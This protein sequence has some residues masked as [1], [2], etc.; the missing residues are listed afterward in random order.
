MIRLLT[1]LLTPS[2]FALR[3]FPATVRAEI[4]TAVAGSEQRHRGEICVVI[5]GPLPFSLLWRDVPPRQRALD[6]FAER[7]VWDTEENSGVL[8]YVQ[9][10]D[11]CVEI[12]ADRGIARRVPQATWDD[13]C[14]DLA[15]ALRA[16]RYREGV[17]T[18]IDAV[19]RL[20]AE[21]FPASEDNPNEL[22]DVPVVLD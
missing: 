9:L 12:V 14:H 3:H 1:H 8:I 10:V 16:G 15:A 11:R 5:E 6:L 20:L 2:W 17:L 7:R 13:L 19:T 18:A 21:H 4:A 22:P